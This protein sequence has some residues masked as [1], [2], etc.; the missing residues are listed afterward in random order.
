MSQ[1]G[2]P[3]WSIAQI[4]QAPVPDPTVYHFVTEML[5]SGTLWD[6]GLWHCG[7]CELGQVIHHEYLAS[8]E[9][10]SK[11]MGSLNWGDCHNLK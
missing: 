4:P 2:N 3:Q 5:Q 10:A 8:T 1:D 7:I 6:M 11:Y 9:A